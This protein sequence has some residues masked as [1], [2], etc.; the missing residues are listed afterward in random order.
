MQADLQR[1]R[2]REY[3]S[4]DGPWDPISGGASAL[5]GTLGSLMMGFAD[6]P[7]EILRAL[8]VKPSK[9]RGDSEGSRLRLQLS[10]KTGKNADPVFLEL[11]SHQ[12]ER[13]QSPAIPQ[14]YHSIPRQQGW[15]TAKT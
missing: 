5:L 11:Q 3:D 4:E 6:F 8:K 9:N 1:Y 10:L 14:N 12:L 2:P 7:V 13:D 15:G